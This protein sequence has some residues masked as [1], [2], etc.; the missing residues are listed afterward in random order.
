MRHLR[1]N[2]LIVAVNLIVSSFSCSLDAMIAGRPKGATL[3]MEKRKATLAKLANLKKGGITPLKIWQGEEGLV[4]AASCKKNEF[5]IHERGSYF[6]I[7][8]PGDVVKISKTL[9]NM[10]TDIV[11]NV[12]TA[13]G[14]QSKSIPLNFPAAVIKNTFYVLKIYEENKNQSKEKIAESIKKAI[15]GY[16]SERLV[17]VVNCIHHLDCPENVQNVC[18]YEI[19]NKYKDNIDAIVADKELEKLNSDLQKPLKSLITQ[20][21]IAYLSGLFQKKNVQTT[22]KVL[23]NYADSDGRER[24]ISSVAL[25]FDGTIIIEGLHQRFAIRN[26]PTSKTLVNQKLEEFHYVDQVAMN[27][28]GTKVVIG[29]HDHLE[30]WDANTGNLIHNLTGHWGDIN[31]VA[32]SPDGTKIVSGSGGNANGY[33]NNLM[34]WDVATGTLIANIVGPHKPVFSVAFNS[35][36]TKVV[37]GYGN[38]SD[39]A[40]IL[41]YDFVT[42][43]AKKKLFKGFGNDI[44]SVSFSPDDTK[45]LY[46]GRKRSDMVAKAYLLDID[47]GINM[48]FSPDYSLIT[49][50]S[51][52]FTGNQ[53]ND[54]FKALFACDGRTIIIGEPFGIQI[55]NIDNN[56][57]IVQETYLDITLSESKLSSMA[58]SLNGQKVIFGCSAIHGGNSPLV[59]ECTLWTDQDEAMINQLKNCTFSETKLI[60]KLYSELKKQSSVKKLSIG[61]ADADIFQHL[62]E[63][64]QQALSNIFWPAEKPKQK[65]WFW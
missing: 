60:F 28:E 62:P 43:P 51:T 63:N 39:T 32:F 14:D 54:P 5:F 56:Y 27:P 49:H 10:I 57:N 65:G 13:T 7:C 3:S 48:Q 25:N 59:V 52:F 50:W 31:S 22:K 24:L 6:G 11:E 41:M 19:K 64:I 12:A 20:P 30:I 2:T 18:F 47:K 46:V 23:R 34:V 16:S 42:V 61:S 40:V 9:N 58:I 17:D 35:D 26:I 53:L 55:L 38:V 37:A 8:V 1:V 4:D 36:G 33:Y 29:D 45:I 44:Y 21:I 15:A